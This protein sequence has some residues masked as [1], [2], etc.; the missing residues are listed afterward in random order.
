[1]TSDKVSL[2]QDPVPLLTEV[3]RHIL[4][5]LLETKAIDFEALGR[6]IASVG[7]ESI[8]MDD[9]GWIRWCGS[10]MRIYRW[11]KPRFGLEDVGLLRQIVREEI[12]KSR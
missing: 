10:D 8:L 1:M 5:T 9:D 11:P 7:P 12:L 6:T 4:A 3:D 2:P